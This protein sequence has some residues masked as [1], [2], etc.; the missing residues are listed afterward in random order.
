MS[1][2]TEGEHA[3][4]R[5][6]TRYDLA[7]PLRYRKAGMTN[8]CD[9]TCENICFGGLMLVSREA[10]TPGDVLNLTLPYPDDPR[11]GGLEIQ[12]TVIWTDAYA[13]PDPAGAPCHHVGVQFMNVSAALFQEL[14]QFLHKYCKG[15]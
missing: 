8:A 2:K 5:R 9:T 10:L 3:E 15:A 4:R 12:G 6:H 7:M 1:E 11:S 13:H 14:E